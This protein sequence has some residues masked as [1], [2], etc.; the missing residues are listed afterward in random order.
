MQA[1]ATRGHSISSWPNCLLATADLILN[2]TSSLFLTSMF[3][4]P[5]STRSSKISIVLLMA[6]V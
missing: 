5:F 1:S 4:E 6:L 2:T 3:S